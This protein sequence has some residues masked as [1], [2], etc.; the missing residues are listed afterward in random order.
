MSIQMNFRLV[1][2]LAMILAVGLSA[3]CGQVQ[4]QGTNET[5]SEPDQTGYGTLALSS[6]R[7]PEAAKS[8][9]LVI[10]QVGGGD[11]HCHKVLALPPKLP[12]KEVYSGMGLQTVAKPDRNDCVPVLYKD[13]V[14][15]AANDHVSTE[16][17]RVIHIKLGE[18]VK[19]IRL[20][21]GTYTVRA[22]F[23][24]A[25]KQL[26]YTGS[27]IFGIINGDRTAVTVRLK[28]VEAGEVTI[29]FEIEKPEVL[30]TKISDDA[31]VELQK[32]EGFLARQ[33]LSK[34]IDLDLSAGVA[35]VSTECRAPVACSGAI[36]MQK[37]KLSKAQLIT[38]SSILQTVSLKN[39]KKDNAMMCAA[40]VDGISLVLKRCK[41]CQAGAVHKFV[42]YACGQPYHTLTSA[43]FDRIWSILNDVP[44]ASIIQAAR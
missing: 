9:V 35:V 8:L 42:N 21:S 33:Q 6:E 39:G 28:K 29:G 11:D 24:D 18:A 10:Q 2:R 14:A 12:N 5:A 20:R 37:I 19:P 1:S 15:N 4:L 36:K 44:A 13:G 34:N 30:P 7:F 43:Q 38:F 32:I 16:A 31:H 22:D 40:P 25:S 3:A 27:E 17:V 23:L 41:E 26:L